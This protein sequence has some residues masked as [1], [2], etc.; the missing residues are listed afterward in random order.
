[1]YTLTDDTAYVTSATGYPGIISS[2]ITSISLSFIPLF[3]VCTKLF[4]DIQTHI[5]F[6]SLLYFP[7]PLTLIFQIVKLYLK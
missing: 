6:H 4:Y 3:R 2:L 1:M 7:K 5:T